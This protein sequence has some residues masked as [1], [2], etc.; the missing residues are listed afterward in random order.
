MNKYITVYKI[1]KFTQ[2]LDASEISVFDSI[3]DANDYIYEEHLEDYKNGDQFLIVQT[4]N[5]GS[6]K[7]IKTYL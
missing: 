2:G 4:F 7:I 6:S 5:D 1:D 3:T